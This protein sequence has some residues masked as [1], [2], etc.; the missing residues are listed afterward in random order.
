VSHLYE[1][2]VT[3]TT[4]ALAEHI[5]T[6]FPA[7]PR[8]EIRELGIY[9]ASAVAGEIGLGRPAAQAAGTISGGVT[10]QAGDPADAAGATILA[11]QNGS[12]TTFGTTQPTAPTNF[13]RRMQLPGVIGAGMVWAWGPGEMIATSAA[14]LVLWQVSTAAVTYKVYA[15]IVE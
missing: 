9:V 4:G 2:A 15:K 11:P 3:V 1:A 8:A 12:N 7:T 5:A 6:I 14:Q 13:M 10:V